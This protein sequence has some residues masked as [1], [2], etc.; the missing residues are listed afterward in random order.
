MNESENYTQFSVYPNSSLI[1][2]RLLTYLESESVQGDT[3]PSKS[4]PLSTNQFRLL[5]VYGWQV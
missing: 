5:L 4:S 3:S 2:T 1:K